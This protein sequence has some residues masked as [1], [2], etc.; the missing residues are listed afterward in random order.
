M[1]KLKKSIYVL[2]SFIM[3][4]MLFAN[5]QPVAAAKRKVVWIEKT[6]EASDTVT[7][8]MIDGYLKEHKPV[9]LIVKGNK[10]ASKK[11]ID[12]LRKEI[13]SVNKQGV[14]FQ[15]ELAKGKL[16][17]KKTNET[18]YEISEENA[19]LYDYSVKFIKK[20]HD[21]VKK[22]YNYKILSS[23]HTY[24]DLEEL[25]LKKLFG[26]NQNDYEHFKENYKKLRLKM[27]YNRLIFSLEKKFDEIKEKTSEVTDLNYKLNFNGI[28]EDDFGIFFRK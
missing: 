19:K 10:K 14:I 4:S 21:Y 5:V 17:N 18:L 25:V 8:E 27:L 1:I 23:L 2:I 13:Q 22:G 6:V 9:K 24:S 16:N 11:V 12:G 20:L 3:L 26:E 28:T 7:A 15:Y